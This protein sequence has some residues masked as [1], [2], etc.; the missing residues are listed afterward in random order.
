[1]SGAEAD[2]FCCSLVGFNQ[3]SPRETDRGWRVGGGRATFRIAKVNFRGTQT[4]YPQEEFALKFILVANLESG[5]LG[6]CVPLT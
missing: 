6:N 3:I 2:G 5:S 4:T 1:M